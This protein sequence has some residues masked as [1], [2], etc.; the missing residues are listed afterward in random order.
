MDHLKHNRRAWNRQSADACVWSRPVD[1]ATVARARQGQWQVILTPSQP[2]PNAWFGE[3][4]GKRVLCLAS[5]GGQQAPILA[6]AG[7]RVV[8]FDLSEEQL[9]K[10]RMTAERESLSIACVQ[11]DM[12]NLSCFRDE[13]FDLVFHPSANSFVPDVRPVWRECHRVLRE[14]GELLAGFTNPA[15]FMFDHDEADGS[16]VLTVKHALPYSD[17]GTL[18]EKEL[19]RMLEEGEPVQFSH[20]LD[21]QIGGQIDAGFA[22]IGF[23]EDHWFDD[24]WLYSTMAPIS[25]ATRARKSE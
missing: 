17:A 15:V 5:G 19:Y 16:G 2:V 10:D 11:G 4:A 14:G 23:Y 21:K 9:A 6:T 25:I 12:A 7:A 1:A 8:S 3:I 22:I 13:V 20:S 24:T 18:P